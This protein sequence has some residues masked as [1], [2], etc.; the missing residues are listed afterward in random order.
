VVAE[1]DA[2]NL[3]DSGLK[4]WQLEMLAQRLSEI[5]QTG[6]DYG[7]DKSIRSPESKR[8]SRYRQCYFNPISCF[9][10]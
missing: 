1:G 7:W 5:S 10:K 6:G 2:N 9:R 8:Q 3:L 4:P